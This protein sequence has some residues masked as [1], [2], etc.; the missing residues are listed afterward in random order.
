MSRRFPWANAHRVADDH[1]LEVAKIERDADR[2]AYSRADF[3][4]THP[5]IYLPD[6]L[7]LEL[8]HESREAKHFVI[9]VIVCLGAGAAVAWGLYFWAVTL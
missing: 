9:L 4:G 3:F 1:R 2:R 5:S 7:E 6:E 8:A